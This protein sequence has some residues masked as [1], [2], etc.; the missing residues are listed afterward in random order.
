MAQSVKH[1]TRDFGSGH[2]LTVHRIKPRVGLSSDSIEPAWDSRSPFLPLPLPHYAHTLSQNKQTKFNNAL[3][4]LF[5]MTKWDLSE[6]EGYFN[7]SKLINVIPHN[8]IKCI[9]HVII[10]IEVLKAFGKTQHLF[11]VKST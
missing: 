3:K 2:N 4:G 6:I 8:R 1:L 7:I 5:I 11:M 9:N 10:S